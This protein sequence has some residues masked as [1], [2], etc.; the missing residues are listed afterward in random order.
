MPMLRSAAASKTANEDRPTAT[1]TPLTATA[2]PTLPIIRSI[3]IST[4]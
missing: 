3:A 1:A 2:L 4:E